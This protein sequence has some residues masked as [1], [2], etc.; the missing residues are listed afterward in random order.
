M[1]AGRA[2]IPAAWR[3]ECEVL[4]KTKPSARSIRFFPA[5]H[6]QATSGCGIWIPALPLFSE[7]LS[8]YCE[9]SD[10]LGWDR[11]HA[12]KALNGKV[13]L[14]Q[15]ARKRGSKATY[16]EE[17]REV[18]VEIWKRSEQPCGKPLKPTTP[19]GW[20]ATKSTT[21]SFQRKPAARSCNAAH[22]S[23]TVSPRRT[24]AAT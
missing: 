20:T 16:T 9:V 8:E 18:V 19:S 23:S 3:C 14:G 6:A 15:G 4:E 22:A 24:N 1:T 7:R 13:S 17:V 5:I 12:I 21:A 2:H 11:N 10:T